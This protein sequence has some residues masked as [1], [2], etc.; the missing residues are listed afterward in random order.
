MHMVKLR[1]LERKDLTFVHQLDNN[2]S[3]MRYWF[4][5]PY[6]AFVELV[7]LYNKHIHDQTERRFIIE[8]QKTKV[9][10]VELMEINYIHRRSEF[11]IIIDPNYQ[12]KGFASFAANLAMDY[13]FSILNLYKLYLIVDKENK[14]AIYI[15][16]KLGFEIEGELIHEFFINGEYR[17]TIRMCIFQ[18]QYLEKVKNLKLSKKKIKFFG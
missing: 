8:Y 6:E 11:Q 3:V 14:K 15:Y 18:K 16:T 10:L 9:G 17:N 12:G 13:A 4:E 2:A 1:P 5:E 7:D